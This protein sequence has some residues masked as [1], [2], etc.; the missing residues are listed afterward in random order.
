MSSSVSISHMMGP[1]DSSARYHYA[2]KEIVERES[3]LERTQLCEVHETHN[4]H[5]ETSP[6][7]VQGSRLRKLVDGSVAGVKHV[8]ISERTLH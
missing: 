8:G 7:Y 6:V 4:S 1:E 3:S 5:S 2:S